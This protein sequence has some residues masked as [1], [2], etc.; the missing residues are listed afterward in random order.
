M[1][2]HPAAETV[3]ILAFIVRVVPVCTCWV[4]DEGVRV[5]VTWLDWTLRQSSGTVGGSSALLPHAMEMEGRALS[6]KIVVD[7]DNNRVTYVRF[8]LW[9]RPRSV[10]ADDLTRDAIWRSLC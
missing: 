9:A 6:T 10:D 5:R 7:S 2:D 4:G 3:G 1:D 8:D